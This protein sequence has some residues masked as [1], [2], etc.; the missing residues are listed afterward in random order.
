[1]PSSTAST[2]G[3]R[4]GAEEGEQPVAVQR[5][6]RRQ[7]QLDLALRG[8]PAAAPGAAAQLAGRARVDRADRLVELAHAAEPGRQRHL[9]EAQPGRLDQRAG[10]LRALGP[11][12]LGRPGPHLCDQDPVELALAEAEPGGQAGDAVAVDDPVRDQADGAA[13]DVGAPVPGGR[14]RRGVRLAALAGP[15]A[16]RLR[17]RGR[18]EQADVAPV[19]QARR[20]AGAAVDPG[21]RDADEEEAVVARVAAAHEAVA[22]LE[23]VDHGSKRGSLRGASLAV[24]RHV[25]FPPD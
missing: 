2:P 16:G 1:M 10:R 8:R 17:G 12:Q 5:C 21:R 7:A 15:E 22:G 3:T 23:V 14:A 18:R 20:A 24:F 6:A 19:G 25:R 9:G 11:R 13:C 4:A